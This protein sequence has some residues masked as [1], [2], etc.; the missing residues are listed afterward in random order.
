MAGFPS[1]VGVQPAPGVAGDFASINPRAV[2]L[3]GPSDLVAGASGVTVAAFGW[4]DPAIFG[5]VTNNAPGPTT[6][7]GVSQV[8]GVVGRQGQFGLV[9]AYLA[10]GSMVI[11]TGQPVT[12][13]TE[14]DFWAINSGTG[15]ARYGQKAYASLTGGALT[16]NATGTPTTATAATSSIAAAT[17]ISAIGAI[18]G[19]VLIVASVSAGTIVPGAILTGTS[20]ATGTQV[21]QQIS[22]TTGGVGQYFVNIADQSVPAGTAISGTYGI[23]TLGA[24]PSANFTQGSV[25]SGSGVTTGTVLWS[26]PT[27]QANGGTAIVSPSQTASSTTIT[28]TLNVETK[29]YAVSNAP[30]GGLIKISSWPLG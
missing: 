6:G 14:G 28:A 9:T 20:V 1:Q 13:Y 15:E 11:P 25:L 19:N 17:G 22:G 29:W 18:A 4:I 12:L 3:A 2:A 26:Q 5:T 21:T 30:A 8:G 16:F 24:T 10:E 23:L 27:L 7:V